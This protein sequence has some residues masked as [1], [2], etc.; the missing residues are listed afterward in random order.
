MIKFTSKKV[1]FPDIVRRL[2]K[3]DS[4]VIDCYDDPEK[5]LSKV[6]AF[7]EAFFMEAKGVKRF[8]FYVTTGKTFNESFKLKENFDDA[9]FIAFIDRKYFNNYVRYDRTA[10]NGL[11]LSEIVSK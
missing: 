1:S 2:C 4:I 6:T 10:F 7:S 8:D 11:F 5:M 3:E 9:H